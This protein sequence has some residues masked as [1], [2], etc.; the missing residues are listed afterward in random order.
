MGPLDMGRSLD[1]G[2]HIPEICDW[3]A[4]FVILIFNIVEVPSHAN[5]ILRTDQG[6]VNMLVLCFR[7]VRVSDAPQGVGYC[8]KSQAYQ[9]LCIN[10][11]LK[12]YPVCDGLLLGIAGSSELCGVKAR[13]MV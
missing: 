13:G 12:G 10:R 11:L 9:V 5:K 3:T 2:Y 4:A 1:V 7:P 6:P 8:D